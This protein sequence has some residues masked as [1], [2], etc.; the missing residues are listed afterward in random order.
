MIERKPFIV[1]CAGGL[2]R[3]VIWLARETQEW[4]PIG[5]LVDLEYVQ[6]QEICGVPFLGSIDDW[7]QFPGA[8]FAVAIGSPRH[9]K[10]IVE[11]M[12]RLDPP[13]F[14]TIIHPSVQRSSY[15]TI[16][17][18]SIITAGCIL[19]TQIEI[20]K[21]SLVNIGC[22]VG[23]DVIIGDFCTISPKVAV[24]GNTVLGIGVEIGTGATLIEKLSVGIGTFI[25]A[26]SV[27]TK[28]LPDNVFAVGN[29]ARQIKTLE[30]FY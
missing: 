12:V 24:S 1:V 29:P 9:R 6:E 28:S 22:T 5:F 13:P 4:D 30:Q 25:G 16:K 27:L 15:V 17:E 3:E 23:H 19:T 8:Y 2:A 7:P 26:G 21:H 18:G 11:R 14:A 20:G 10:R